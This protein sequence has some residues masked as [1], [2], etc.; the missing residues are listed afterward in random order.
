LLPPSSDKNGV[1]TGKKNPT[2]YFGLSALITRFTT[3]VTTDPSF[4]TAALLVNI[5]VHIGKPIVAPN[6]EEVKPADGV[7]VIPT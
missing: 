7:P 2:Y 4:V 1:D 3:L 5:P 6:S